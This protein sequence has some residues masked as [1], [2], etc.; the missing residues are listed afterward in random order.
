[1]EKVIAI[2]NLSHVYCF[3]YIYELFSYRLSH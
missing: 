3:A 2:K 1:M